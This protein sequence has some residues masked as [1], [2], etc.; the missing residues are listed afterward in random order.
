MES[1]VKSRHVYGYGYGYHNIQFIGGS[2]YSNL[3]IFHKFLTRCA[4]PIDEIFSIST[5]FQ[6]FSPILTLTASAHRFS[7]SLKVPIIAGRHRGFSNM[8]G[9]CIPDSTFEHCYK[10]CCI[11]P[12][13]TFLYVYVLYFLWRFRRRSDASRDPRIHSSWIRR[14]VFT[15]SERKRVADTMWMMTERSTDPPGTGGS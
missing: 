3:F 13:S 11:A 12:I 10:G 1:L 6:T 7:D 14:Q 5:R 4:I 9:L 8:K 15:R 2:K